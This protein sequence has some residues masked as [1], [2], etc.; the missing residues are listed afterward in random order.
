MRILAFIY[1][2]KKLE[3][4]LALIVGLLTRRRVL[5]A[6]PRVPQPARRVRRQPQARRDLP[7]P[8]QRAVAVPPTEPR[9]CGAAAALGGGS[10]RH[11]Q[12]DRERRCR[13]RRART[14]RARPRQ[15]RPH[16]AEQPGSR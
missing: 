10:R 5:H 7:P 6:Q 2:L 9:R 13:A 4:R 1:L 11:P 16:G 12:G 14:S 3:K 15:P 8:H